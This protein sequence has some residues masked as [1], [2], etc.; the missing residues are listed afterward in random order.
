MQKIFTLLLLF[1]LSTWSYGQVYLEEFDDDNVEYMGGSGSYSF[2]EANGELT[3]QATNTAP[4][5][6]FTY[7]PND[8]SET[9]NVDASEN[10]KIFVRAKAS[11]VGTQLRMDLQDADG[12]GTSL[13]GITKTLTTEYQVLEFDF[14]GLYQDGGYGGTPCTSDTAPCTVD[15]SQVA[16]F[17]FFTDPGV[18]GFNGTVVIDYIALGEE[19]ETVAMSDV[20]QDH[21]EQDS[22]INSFSVIGPGYDVV[23]NGDSEVVITGNGTNPMWDPITYFFRN[24][25]TLDTIDIDVSGNNKLFVKVKSTVENT[26]LRI[27]VQDIDGF[28]NTQGS[29][30]KILG[31]DYQIIEYDYSGTYQDLGYGGTPCT[32]STA[33][34]PVD[35]SRIG[36][37]VMF[38]EPGVGEFL[39][40]IKID[41]ISF[42]TSLEPP[43]DE[44]I[45]IYGDHF[46]NELLEYT[47]EGAGFAQSEMNSE[48]VITGDGS[49]PQYTALAYSFHDKDTG[50]GIT[51]DMTPGKN[52][53]FVRAKSEPGTAPLRLDLVDT[54]GFITSQASLTKIIGNEYTTYE[55]DFT[56]NNLDGGFGGT[57]CEVGPC[58]TDL[59]AITTVLF[60]VDPVQAAYEGTFTVDFLSV[61]QPLGED[62]E[63][64]LGPTGEINYSDQMDD[65]T[66][67]FVAD[68]SGLVSAFATDEWTITGDGS[69]GAFSP[70]LYN[71]HNTTGELGL[72]DVQGS[73]NK[74]FVRAKSS[75]AGT[76]LRIDLQDNMTF[77]TNLNSV[78]VNLT[79][80]YAVYEL[81]YT[82]S[83][84][85]GAFGGSDCMESGCVVDGQRIENLQVFIDAAAGGFNGA[86]SIDWLS[87]G[88]PLVSDVQ[89]FTRLETL[90]AFP[91][92][93]QDQLSIQYTTLQAADVQ[94]NVFNSLGQQVVVQK[95]GQQSASNQTIILPTA[96]LQ[97]GLYTVQLVMDSKVVGYLPFVKM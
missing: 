40:E 11:N 32:E 73:G 21:F 48:W 23:L 49:A 75:V 3:V 52:K 79:E 27:D 78:A 18:G 57:A 90:V 91:N 94:L 72:A 15:G 56:G 62:D 66:G 93:V 70:L 9:I 24:P 81:D 44:A 29:V 25:I 58:P 84:Q 5:D 28:V 83:Y 64:D 17:L 6:V 36:Q 87:F 2:A 42:G 71:V 68:A 97:N 59:T 88:E 4:F 46:G 14:T 22:S 96:N 50:E 20:F 76:E 8:G 34:C 31:T 60:Y 74:L 1:G 39:G 89:D 35:P 55:Y 51:L 10:N 82:N 19:P 33:P 85:D 38:I 54:S 92:P 65:N 63:V 43:G 37:I 95:I 77:V 67:L 26:A 53:V 61:G 80:E 47:G 41:Y 7:Q 12:F 45:G 30:T 16:Q 13:A 86:V 69:A